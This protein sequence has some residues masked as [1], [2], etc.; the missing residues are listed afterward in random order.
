M[1]DQPLLWLSGGMVAMFVLIALHVPIG[2]SMALVGF[3]GTSLILGMEPALSILAVEPVSAL[4]SLDLA[5]VPLFLL[6]GGFAASAGI[7]SDLFNLAARLIGHR[8]GGLAMAT[9]GG[10]AGFGAICG[11]SIAN[12]ATMSKVALPEMQSRGYGGSISA[13]SIAAGGSL[14]ILIPPSIIMVIYAVLTEQFVLTRVNAIT[15]RCADHQRNRLGNRVGH[16]NAL[17]FEWS[18]FKRLPDR[19]AD[20]DGRP[21]N[22]DMTLGHTFARGPAAVAFDADMGA[23]IQP[24]AIIANRTFKR[25]IGTIGQTNAKVVP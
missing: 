21:T 17:D 16:V 20:F 18:D 11:S 13:G 10:C 1:V 25:D 19:P 4:S 23:G 3:V 24:A 12:T 7:A 15:Q 6:M 2:V 14:A 22:F 5:T 9:V 8:R